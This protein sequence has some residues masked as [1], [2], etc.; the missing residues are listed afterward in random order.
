ME[1]KEIHD[2][3]LRCTSVSIDTRKI[4]EGSMF[5]AIRG[6][7]FDANTFAQEALNKGALY[8]IIDNKDYYIDEKTILVANTLE[9]LQEVAKFHGNIWDCQFWH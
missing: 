8:V 6:E 1:I 4:E 5:F 7:H 2:L 9:T 3:F